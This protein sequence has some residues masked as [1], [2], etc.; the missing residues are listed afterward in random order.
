MS[1]ELSGME[2]W[3]DGIQ[4]PVHV[5]DNAGV[6]PGHALLAAGIYPGGHDAVLHKPIDVLE[7]G[8]HPEWTTG[9]AAARVHQILATGAHL[10]LGQLN[11]EPILD[12]TLLADFIADARNHGLEQNVRSSLVF[13]GTPTGH[14]V[15]V[16]LLGAE[17]FRYRKTQRLDVICNGIT[18]VKNLKFKLIEHNNPPFIT[19]ARS[20]RMRP[21]SLLKRR[22]RLNSGCT[23]DDSTAYSSAGSAQSRSI[24]LPDSSRYTL[25]S[26]ALLRV[27]S[28]RRALILEE[29]L[30]LCY[31]V[32]HL[33]RK[34]RG[35]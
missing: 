21:M 30:N 19:T 3:L 4:D 32:K 25:Q 5:V 23:A 8:A 6:D 31:A 13:R 18:L 28:P 22:G 11:V 1:I 20:S 10:Q 12:H 14:E 29:N 34:V 2:L 24:S 26:M 16:E 33:Y 15:L 7:V 17:I 9:V 27:C 35:L